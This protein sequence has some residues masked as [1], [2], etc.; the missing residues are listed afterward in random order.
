[1]TSDLPEGYETFSVR[2]D[3][4]MPVATKGG[5]PKAEEVAAQVV[6]QCLPA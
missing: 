1:M 2:L 3:V 6:G 4:T 5:R